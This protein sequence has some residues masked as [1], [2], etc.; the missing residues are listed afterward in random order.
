MEIISLLQKTVHSCRLKVNLTTA[1][2]FTNLKAETQRPFRRGFRLKIV[3]KAHLCKKPN[4]L[5]T[6]L[7][8]SDKTRQISL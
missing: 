1:G 6:R 4:M 8:Q 5:M 7:I 3:P 2:A